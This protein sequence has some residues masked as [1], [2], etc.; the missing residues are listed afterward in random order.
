MQLSADQL[1][2]QVSLEH[3]NIEDTRELVG[4]ADF[5][6]QPRAKEAL[7]FGVRMH[8][9]GYNLYVMGEN[10]TGRQSLV[11][12]YV[13]QVAAK[14]SATNDW[15]YVHNFD[16]QRDPIAIEL[17]A[18]QGKKLLS[19]MEG[20][21]NDLLD[22]F[23]ATFENP[24]YQRRRGMIERNFSKRYDQAIALVEKEANQHNIAV[25]TEENTLVFTPVMDGKPLDENEVAQLPDD[26]RSK[27]VECI[28]DL[29]DL[30]TEALLELPQWK[31]ETN[32]ALRQLNIDTI[33]LAVKPLLKDLEHEWHSNIQLQKFFRQIKQHIARIILEM[34][35]DDVLGEVRPDNER[36]QQLN[37]VFLPN[38]L[39]SSQPEDG[40]AVVYELLPTWQNLFG[41]IEYSIHQ[42]APT[43]SYQY[44][45]PGA[46]HKANGGYLILDAE[47]LLVEPFAYESLKLALQTKEINMES[48]FH[49]SSIYNPVT[50]SPAPMPLRVKIILIGSREVYYQLLDMD[51]EFNELFRVLVDF[52]ST[53]P[54]T[55]NTKH[56][57]VLRVKHYAEERGYLPIAR[58][59]LERLIEF[60]LRQAE[61]QDKITARVVS[62]FKVLGEAEF[63][64]R[65]KDAERIERT[66][67][68][69]A[70]VSAQR[71]NGR[72]AEQMHEEISDGTILIDCE[73]ER[74][75]RVNGL[76]VIEIGESLFGSPARIT[77]TC[78][79]GSK[80][81]VDIEREAELGQA[82][83]TKGVM[84]LTGYFGHTFGRDFSLHFSASIAMEQSYG[85]VD[86]DSATVAETCAL[87]SS[88]AEVPIKQS[89]AVTGS[90]N[91]HG[92]IQAVGGVNEKIEGF[93]RL[94][95]S[96]GLSGEQGVIIP[97]DNVKHLMLNDEVVKAVRDGQFKVWAV[98]HLFEAAELLTGMPAG[99]LDKDGKFPSDTLNH[100][101]HERLKALHDA[102][103]SDDTGEEEDETSS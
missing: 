32:E 34:F 77:A 92:D 88:I 97:R 31:R 76:T 87:L 53:L 93:Y 90:M 102:E 27:V 86:G 37:Q 5:L 71:R 83:H 42:G 74:T 66:H 12:H 40:Q 29:E 51:P 73:G 3:L 22:T 95:K 23:P 58:Q 6:G 60:G 21:I 81:I 16:Q 24:S 35:A 14:S 18:G 15:V 46:L 84:I 69:K 70:L 96:R 47:K 45:R 49:E 61:H 64:A 79:A 50:L 9:G 13:K 26:I 80:G 101:V 33:E 41:R 19:D 78:Y 8:G 68:V 7:E 1:K 2:H 56:Q 25:F 44:I 99:K 57:L 65:Q 52:D 20:F 4:S 54:R 89:I 10:G 39:V 85:Y 38:L 82:I 75:G 48:P 62:M 98:S 17:V 11:S 28:G 59:A 100:K 103:L 55:E 94:C 36:R 30:L 43:T 67:V 63:I 72:I 91:Q